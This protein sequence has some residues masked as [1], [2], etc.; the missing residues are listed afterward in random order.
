MKQ[1][2]EI[3]KLTGG[4]YLVLLE[5]ESIFPL[6]AKELEEFGIK[7]EGYLGER[8]IEKIL[9][10]ILPKRSK[11]CAMHFLQSTDRT[12]YQLRKKLESLFYPE[13]IIEEAVSYVKKFHYID[14]M[15]YAV[16]YLECHKDSKSMRQLE[17]ELYKKGISRETFQEAAERSEF[18]EATE[19]IRYWLEKKHYTGQGAEKKETEKICRFLLRKGYRMSDI[20]KVIRCD[21]LYE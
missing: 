5:D 4:R 14:D 10:E 17:Q 16:N 7:E 12:E 19:Q 8:E 20:Q 9:H 11:L 6:Y 15:R 13:D 21:D 2:C 1:I 18:P 3:K